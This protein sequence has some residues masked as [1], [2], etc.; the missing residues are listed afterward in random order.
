MLRLSL[1]FALLLPLPL[2][3]NPAATDALNTYRESKGRTALTYST[4]LE[5]AAK[6]HADDMVRRGFFSHTGS[7]G[8]D[9]GDRVRKARY[10]WCFVAENIAQGQRGLNAVMQAWIGSTGHRA[11]MLH[12]KAREFALYEAA[13]RTWVMVLAAP[14][15]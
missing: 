9:V 2:S 5:Q 13:D 1:L 4:R 12:R 3:A 11:N 15:R 14:C 7:N 10:E 8:S 6:A